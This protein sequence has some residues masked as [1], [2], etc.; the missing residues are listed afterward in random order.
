MKVELEKIVLSHSKLTDRV[1]AGVLNKK[2]DLFLNK[3]DVSNHFI[4]CVIKRWE[5]QKEVIGAGNQRW[6]ISVKKLK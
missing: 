5:G 4:D 1:F 3:T 6:E 2:G